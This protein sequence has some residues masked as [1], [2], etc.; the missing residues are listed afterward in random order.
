MTTNEENLLQ[1]AFQQAQTHHTQGIE[2]VESIFRM[3]A[4]TPDL[5]TTDN[6]SDIL[7]QVRS[8]TNSVT[9]T[10]ENKKLEEFR[11]NTIEK[12]QQF[13]AKPDN[14]YDSLYN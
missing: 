7:K 9:I 3:I 10:I 13:L 6:P 1:E 11:L 5:S 14:R 4:L 12:I 8:G 2:L